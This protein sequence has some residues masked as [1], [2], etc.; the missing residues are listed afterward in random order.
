[1]HDPP[2]VFRHHTITY[3]YKGEVDQGSPRFLPTF[4][5]TLRDKGV[6]FCRSIL[7]PIQ[8][9]TSPLLPLLPLGTIRHN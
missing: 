1:M 6:Q 9:S 7:D 2:R 4:R 3:E 8:P 5:V